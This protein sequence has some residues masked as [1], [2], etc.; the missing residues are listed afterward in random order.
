M[1]FKNS[2]LASATAKKARSNFIPLNCMQLTKNNHGCPTL[3]GRRIR[4]QQRPKEP[5]SA[6]SEVTIQL[7]GLLGKEQESAS[8]GVRASAGLEHSWL[9]GANNEYLFLA[10]FSVKSHG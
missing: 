8:C 10:L 2:N 9:I 6:I 4:A 3:T 1:I 5:F 7:V